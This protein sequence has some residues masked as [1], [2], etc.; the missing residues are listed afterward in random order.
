MGMDMR[1]G[2]RKRGRLKRSAHVVQL[3]GHLAVV[4]T[5]ILWY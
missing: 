1:Y 3:F 4:E 5:H 2:L